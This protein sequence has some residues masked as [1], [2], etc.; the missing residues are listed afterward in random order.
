LLLPP[1]LR[2]QRWRSSP[3]S[4]GAG[5]LAAVDVP[6]ASKS[7]IASVRTSV[8]GAGVVASAAGGFKPHE[9]RQPFLGLT[10]CIALQGV[11]PS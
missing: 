3:T 8:A 11:F 4:A 7:P 1:L 5:T 9:N 10:F 2:R 6:T